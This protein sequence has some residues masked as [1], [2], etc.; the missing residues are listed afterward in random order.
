VGQRLTR[1]GG[2]AGGARRS[3][4]LSDWS[5]KLLGPPE[6]VEA[7]LREHGESARDP[8]FLPV[9][10]TLHYVER[11]I[12]D[13]DMVAAVGRVVG[14]EATRVRPDAGS[15]THGYRD[16][17]PEVTAGLT[18]ELDALAEGWVLVSLAK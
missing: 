6:R 15:E 18:L 4:E 2:D 16:A 14:I 12:E 7:F 3:R 8:G 10:R 13:G 11:R 9:Y 1:G 17:P 5:G